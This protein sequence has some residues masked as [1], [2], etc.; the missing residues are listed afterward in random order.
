MEANA[1]WLCSKEFTAAAA[2]VLDQCAH[3]DKVQGT[4]FVESNKDIAITIVDK[5]IESG[6]GDD[7]DEDL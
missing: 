6:E 2:R 4:D 7:D 5:A 3:G 1:N